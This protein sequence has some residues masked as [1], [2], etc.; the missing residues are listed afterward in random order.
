MDFQN[1]VLPFNRSLIDTIAN[2]QAELIVHI[3]D[4]SEI[5]PAADDII[6]SGNQIHSIVLRTDKTL[7][8][9]EFSDQWE[10]IPVTLFSPGLGIFRDFQQKFDLI[11][12]LNVRYFFPAD[13]V[14]AIL[15]LQTLSAT[16]FE[17]GVDFEVDKPKWE[18]L[19][20][21]MTYSILMTTSH[22]NIEP[23]SHLAESYH[24]HE[25]ND[26]TSVY[27]DDPNSFLHL[28]SR[29]GVAL[30]SA[31]L[32]SGI[33][34]AEN[35]SEVDSMVECPRL[36]EINKAWRRYFLE[37]LPCSTCVGWRACLGKFERLIDKSGACPAATFF[38]EMLDTLDQRYF[39]IDNRDDQPQPEEMN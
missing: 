23:F 39:E 10:T 20:D 38:E 5:V 12:N 1:I 29:G 13:S 24:P 19:I 11:H 27:F 22:A 32:K 34:I 6:S 15:D 4:I 9:L 2:R 14:Q 8:I 18:A 25:F 33:F 30:T 3:N 26:W 17:C 35:I 28:D 37:N 7:D 16:G 31:D 36:E 21:L